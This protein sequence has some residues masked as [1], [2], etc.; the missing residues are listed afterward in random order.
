VEVEMAEGGRSEGGREVCAGGRRGEHEGRGSRTALQSKSKQRIGI[1]NRTK[2]GAE[3]LRRVTDAAAV[4]FLFPEKEE[5][6]VSNQAPLTACFFQN[7]NA[8]V[9]CENEYFVACDPA[10]RVRVPKHHSKTNRTLVEF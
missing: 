2:R 3:V 1:K 9:V 4:T 10:V 6:P 8:V 5:W 7:T